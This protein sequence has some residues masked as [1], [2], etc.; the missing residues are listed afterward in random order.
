MARR[1]QQACIAGSA[2]RSRGRSGAPARSAHGR[3]GPPGRGRAWPFPAGGRGGRLMGAHGDAWRPA[4]A[5]A[6]I[7]R[8]RGQAPGRR[9]LPH[10]RPA[11][12]GRTARPL[13]AP[14]HAHSPC[15]PPLGRLR[16]G[17]L[18]RRLLPRPWSGGRGCVP[19]APTVLYPPVTSAQRR[20]PSD[21]VPVARPR[22]FGH[23]GRGEIGCPDAVG[24]RIGDGGKP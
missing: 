3:C 12:R 9:R 14:P 10:R 2:P 22:Q 21:F 15:T 18:A 20:C 11:R 7:C 23:V 4:A 24:A 16:Q 8:F 13:R 19:G 1:P 6:C 17:F 5:I